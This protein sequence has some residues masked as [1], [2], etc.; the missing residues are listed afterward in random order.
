LQ[1]LVLRRLDALSEKTQRVVHAAAILGRHFDL[2]VLSAVTSVSE[3]DLLVPIREAQEREVFEA[4][5]SGGLRFVHDKLRET[6][7]GAISPLAAAALHAKAAVVLENRRAGADGTRDQSS[8]IAKHY[9]LSG[10]LQKALALFEKAGDEAIAK[11]AQ[12]D[13]AGFFREALELAELVRGVSAIRRARW[14]RELGAALYESGEI[15]ESNHHLT[16]ALELLECPMPSRSSGA[17]GASLVLNLLVQAGHRLLPG[18]LLHQ[19]VDDSERLLETARTFDRLQQAF[20]YAGDALPMLYACVRTL[21]LAELARPSSDLTVAYANACAVAGVVPARKLVT[22]YQKQALENLRAAPDP[23]S[24]SY[25]LMLSG[26]YLTGIGSW[27][28]AAEVLNRGLAVAK[29][30][31]YTRRTREITGTLAIFDFLSGQFGAA[32][33]R[34]DALHAIA[35]QKDLQSQCWALLSRAQVLLVQG[36]C[37]QALQDIRSAD[38]LVAKLGRPERIWA[39][40]LEAAA[41]AHLGAFDLADETS[42]RALVEIRGAP[43]VNHY[44]ID[45]HAV[46]ADVRVML[47]RRAAL[48]GRPDDDCA[49][50]DRLAN[51]ARKALA[52]M[53]RVFP[54]AEPRSRL[55]DGLV[56]DLRGNRKRAVRY[57]Q[58]S[59]DAAQRLGMRYDEARA[60]LALATVRATDAERH[61]QL[62]LDMM[63]DLG[64]QG[65]ELATVQAPA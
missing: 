59:L 41:H 51:D 50:L 60:H 29:R 52:K 3:N 40:S 65:P 31:N 28:E 35:D 17:L 48:L 39:L 8:D 43:P 14:E 26:V 49:E 11:S 6:A 61:R 23:A 45:A 2:A 55:A 58:A 10:N 9:K 15:A 24:E 25:F 54:V 19:R 27:D 5:E 30:L 22:V 16:K 32:L 64:A 46:C 18:K 42:R 57:F 44:L 62:G 37:E 33:A 34:A 56:Q 1:D 47:A 12:K 4:T 36:K 38:G 63:R 53:V 7:Y 21:N 13:A 20:Y